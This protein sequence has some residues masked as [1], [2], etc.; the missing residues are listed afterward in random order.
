MKNVLIATTLLILSFNLFAADKPY[1][2]GTVWE[3]SYIKVN[4]GKLE[5]YLTNLNSG[6]YAIYE[7]YK[8]KG[9]ITSYKAIGFPRNNPDDWNL[10]LLTE[11]PNWATFD[12]KEEEWEAV[13]EQVFKN[14]QSEDASNGERESIRTLWGSKVGRELIPVISD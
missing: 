3:V 5:D 7:E 6:Y 1:T 11:Y 2:L 13:V 14:K 12:R 4:D 8:A 10:M 9:W